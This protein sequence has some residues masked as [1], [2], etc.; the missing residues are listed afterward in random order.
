MLCRVLIRSTQRHLATV[1]AGGINL[2]ATCLHVSAIPAQ[3]GPRST[4]R[5]RY[6][7]SSK[8]LT[9]FIRKEVFSRPFKSRVLIS[10]VIN[11]QCF[12]TV[13]IL[14]SFCGFKATIFC[15]F[16]YYYF[17]VVPSWG[18]LSLSGAS[19]NLLKISDIS[20]C[21]IVLPNDCCCFLTPLYNFCS[22][23]GRSQGLI[24]KQPRHSL[25]NWFSE[26]FPPT[27]LRRRHAQTVRDSTLSYKIGY[28]IVIKT[29]LNP[30]GHQN[31]ISGPKVKD[32]L[33]KGWI[34]PLG[35]ASSVE[36]L[37]L[38]PAQQLV[39]F[40]TR[41]PQH[42]NN[43]KPTNKIL[44]L[45]ETQLYAKIS[46]IKRHCQLITSFIK[47]RHFKKMILKEGC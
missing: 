11:W 23:H 44:W 17:D 7:Q 47:G 8:H 42:Q 46:T 34:L 16:V 30:E 29:F 12:L 28:V 6:N 24:Y 27:A 3:L 2:Q 18:F 32:I 10:K 25:I 9:M 45:L 14:E 36:G 43:N 22:R 33:L 4:W 13:L 41:L 35:R 19:W 40:C 5:S 39:S 20:W 1:S 26:P 31:P 38:Q 21:F 37:R 15:L